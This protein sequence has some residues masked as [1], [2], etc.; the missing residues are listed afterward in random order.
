MPHISLIAALAKNRVIGNNGS[1]PWNIPGEQKR[2]RDLTYGNVVIM[3][4]KTF[5][6]IFRKLSKPLPGRI[7]LII[8]STTCFSFSDCF[9]FK[10]LKEAIEYSERKF[11]DKE[12]FIGGGAAL[13]KEAVSFA[14]RMYLTEI[15]FEA[16]GDVFFPD[17]DETDFE[18]E[19]NETFS[20]P[21]SYRYVTYT[22]KN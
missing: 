5:E 6:E 17:F 20:K 15:D 21:V 19:I 8:S 3:G 4:R 16:E 18:K 1:I 2:F 10:S 13:Y 9:T 14:D 12:I 22:R 11:P 7:N